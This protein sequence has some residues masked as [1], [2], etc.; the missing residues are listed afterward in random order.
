MT[1]LTLTLA[2]AP[3]QCMDLS[4]L[5]PDRL[6][7]KKI[8]EIRKIHITSG[9]QKLAVQD[10]FTLSGKDANHITIR[11]SCNK[12]CYIGAGMTDGMIEVYGSV[13]D[14]LGKGMRAGTIKVRGNAGHWVGTGMYGG[15]IGIMGR[16]GD[17]L[18]A[19]LPSE[20]TGMHNGTILVTGNAGDRIGERMR[21]GMIIIKGDVGDYCGSCMLA[22]TILVLGGTGN[23]PGF[24]MKRGTLVL[25]NKPVHITASFNSCGLLKMEFLRLLFKQVSK[26][27]RHLVMLKEF[28]PLAERLVGDLA[29]GGKGEILILQPT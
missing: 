2:Q 3:V 28:G 26:M 24:G 21:R 20:Q 13:G 1:A 6:R 15:T 8:N 14:Y 27:N 16:A 18:G 25:A 9:S 17:Y 29:H 5:T 7:G 22:G 19:A 4:P 12:L 23:A 10:L 11:R